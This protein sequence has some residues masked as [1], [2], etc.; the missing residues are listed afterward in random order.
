M[1][2]MGI[3]LVSVLAAAVASWVFGA[4]WYGALFSK[5]WMNAAGLTEERIKGPSG[6]PSPAPFVIS[7]LLEL[8]MA[9]VLA[10]LFLHLA[11]EGIAL[12]AA[13]AGAFF[14]WLG[15]VFATMTVNHR[16]SLA[17]WSLTAIDGGHWL[18][19][20]LI[21]AAVLALMGVR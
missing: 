17:P 6:R 3:S 13:L 2:L 21:Q 8:V 12:G 11:K 9:F 19:V 10:V 14:L 7:F 16:Y 5:P 15:F 1:G 18:G 20:L 4:I